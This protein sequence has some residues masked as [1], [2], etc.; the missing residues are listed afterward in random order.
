MNQAKT[1]CGLCTQE[2]CPGVSWHTRAELLLH[3]HGDDGCEAPERP[4]FHLGLWDTER[5]TSFSEPQIP[6]LR[7]GNHLLDLLFESNSIVDVGR[8]GKFQ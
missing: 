8:K 3:Y 1:R 6:H 4:G 2:C 7:N 5:F